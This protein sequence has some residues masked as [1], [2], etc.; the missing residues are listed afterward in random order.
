MLTLS[1]VFCMVFWTPDDESYMLR[2]DFFLNNLALFEKPISL[3]VLGRFCMRVLWRGVEWKMPIFCPRS[4]FVA[5]SSYA[6][7]IFSKKMQGTNH[8]L[9]A[10]WT[11][12][13]T[14]RPPDIGSTWCT[15]VFL[16]SNRTIGCIL[17]RSATLYGDCMEPDHMA[18]YSLPV[19][20]DSTKNII[21]KTKF[22]CDDPLTV[23][24][25]FLDASRHSK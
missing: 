16:V 3:P 19:L 1:R 20:T 10:F 21:Q 18:K 5:G 7:A 25:V 17:K 24:R 12:G 8:L 14:A 6:M 15:P 4:Q 23:L 9:C 13:F 11:A 22:L 2:A